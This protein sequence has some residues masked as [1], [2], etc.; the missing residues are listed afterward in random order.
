MKPLHRWLALLF[1]LL[2]AVGAFAQTITEQDAIATALAHAPIKARLG[3]RDDW[4]AKAYDSENP[5][6]IWRVNFYSQDGEDWGYADVSPTRGRV[7]YYELYAPATEAQIAEAYDHVRAFFE[8]D[9]TLLELFD[10][11]STTPIY[12]D[13]NG[14]IDG[15]G[16]YVDDGE[17]SLYF[18]VGFEA[19]FTSPRLLAIYFKDMLNYD[20]W[21][22]SKGQEAVAVA[23]ADGRVADALRGVVGWRSESERVEGDVWRVRFLGADGTT[24]ITATLNLRENAVLGVE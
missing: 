6:G 15:W 1:C 17:R 22:T 9:E 2:V 20:E 16:V 5:F 4:R 14:W 13:Y 7:Y 11:P 19:S 8:S 3:G 18:I 10:D 12:V 24:L 23:F 21:Q